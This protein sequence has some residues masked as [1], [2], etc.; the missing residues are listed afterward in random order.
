M[1]GGTPGMRGPT[2]S[3][4]FLLELKHSEDDDMYRPPRAAAQVKKMSRTQTSSAPLNLLDMSVFESALWRN[5]TLFDSQC[6]PLIINSIQSFLFVLEEILV[7]PSFLYFCNLRGLRNPEGQC[8][9]DDCQPMLKEPVFP[10]LPGR[11]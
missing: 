2:S 8:D 4:L 11:T 3:Y 1:K 7:A 6:D 5:R 10:H 9:Q